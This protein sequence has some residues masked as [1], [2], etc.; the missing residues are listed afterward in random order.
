MLDALQ[1]TPESVPCSP[2]FTNQNFLCGNLLEKSQIIIDP[3]QLLIVSSILALFS[4]VS[5]EEIG[6][7]FGLSWL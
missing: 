6:S 1:E 2:E 3:V 5:K 7:K 4:A